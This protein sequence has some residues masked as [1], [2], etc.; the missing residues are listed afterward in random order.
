MRNFQIH[1]GSHNAPFKQNNW[2]DNG[3]TSG[4]KWLRDNGN[5]I[6]TFVLFDRRNMYNDNDVFCGRR[7]KN[8]R[9]RRRRMSNVNPTSHLAWESR[10]INFW[11]LKQM[12]NALTHLEES[13][14][15]ETKKW[16]V[17]HVKN[18]EKRDKFAHSYW[19][20]RSRGLCTLILFYDKHKRSKK[21]GHNGY[22]GV[23]VN[24][25][26]IVSTLR[27]FVWPATIDGIDMDL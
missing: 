10:I 27:C 8:P 20:C 13:G 12:K 4:F 18:V 1:C 7:S 24:R 26:P 3:Q 2:I 22:H 21:K 6:I 23:V 14:N 5:S 25:V 9:I 17:S 15:D 11:G 16:G 19:K